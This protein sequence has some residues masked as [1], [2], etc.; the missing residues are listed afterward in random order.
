VA[1]S[2]DG[3]AAARRHAGDGGPVLWF[4]RDGREYV[5]R[6]S[7]LL[8]QVRDKLAA[9]STERGDA[10]LEGLSRE[11]QQEMQAVVEAA[12]ATTADSET[13]RRLADLARAEAE[14]AMAQA[15]KHLEA[16]KDARD[17]AASR[18]AASERAARDGER[19][20]RRAELQR[21]A[22][23]IADEHAA[24]AREQANLA[25]R[26][27]EL[28]AKIAEKARRHAGH[29]SQVEGSVRRLIDEALASGRA[30][31]VR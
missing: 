1:G 31:P 23:R 26:H 25:G 15:A 27:R 9:A 3:L 24:V 6:D 20:T 10:E 19:A 28:A 16:T 4:R 30:T 11:L 5:V 22:R 12:R 29:A 14:S 17:P 7:D 18:R 8:A 21:L 2:R 13:A